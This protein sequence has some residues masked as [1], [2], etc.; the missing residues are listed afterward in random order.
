MFETKLTNL[1]WATTSVLLV[2]I[3]GFIVFVIIYHKRY[4]KLLQEKI[5]QEKLQETYLVEAIIKSQEKERK[6]IGE[7]LHDDIAPILASVIMNLDTQIQVN[8]GKNIA[9]T[10]KAI[11]SIE[12]VINKVRETSHLLHPST[13]EKVGF[14]RSLED[15][16][17]AMNSSKGCN[18]EI[19][20]ILH[21]LPFD[22]FRQIAL[23]HIAQE[24]VLNAIKHGKAKNFKINIFKK[25]DKLILI[26]FHNG[27]K[28]MWNDYLKGLESTDGLGLKNIQYRLKLLDGL[29]SFKS[30]D[31]NFE[32]SVHLQIPMAQTFST[33]YDK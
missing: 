32:Q 2:L 24:I 22:S 6:R 28:F 11:L 17:L 13:F 12:N 9:H 18:I 5:V 8:G 31:V 3:I 10:Q 19:H 16:C 1:I 26:V 15:F 25:E 23:Y 21:Y 29:I 27:G 30:D 33:A 20:S 4:F 7:G 14:F